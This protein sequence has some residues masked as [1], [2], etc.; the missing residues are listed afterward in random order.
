MAASLT[1]APFAGVP[2]TAS[3]VAPGPDTLVV[4]I[5]DRNGGCALA[6]GVLFSRSESV[7]HGAKHRRKE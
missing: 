7:Q 2:P 3:N 5:W 1:D 6:F 4:Q